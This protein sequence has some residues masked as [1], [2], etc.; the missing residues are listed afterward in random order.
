VR[1]I[2]EKKGLTYPPKAILCGAFKKEGVVELWGAES[3][4]GPYVLLKAY[5]ICA[6]SGALG[7]ETA[8]WRHAGARRILRARLV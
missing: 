2:V 7:A 5:G 3:N 1:S 8:I 6:T 4:S